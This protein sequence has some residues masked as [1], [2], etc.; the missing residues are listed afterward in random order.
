MVL[1]KASPNRERDKPVSFRLSREAFK[2]LQALSDVLG[3][4]KTE[5]IEECLI[6]AYTAAKKTYPSD[7]SKAEKKK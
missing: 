5:V 4:S 7:F 3:K 2:Q 6:E 1:K